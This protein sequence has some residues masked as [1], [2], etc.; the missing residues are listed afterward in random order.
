MKAREKKKLK[1]K[2][3]GFIAIARH[4]GVEGDPINNHS[5]HLALGRAIWG[6]NHPELQDRTQDRTQETLRVDIITQYTPATWAAL[7][8]KEKQKIKFHDL[9]LTTIA[10]RFGVEGDPTSNHSMHLTLGRAIWGENHPE[11]QEPEKVE[12]TLDMLMTDL[13]THYTPATWVGMS[14]KEKSKLKSHDLGLSS[15]ATRFDIEGDPRGNH[16]IHLALG[17]AIWGDKWVESEVG[18]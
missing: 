17:R 5:I 3:L 18:K 13:T 8:A 9:G 6:E 10:T 16:S 4:F 14:K 15:I 12:V 2:N 7:K 1:F 11:L